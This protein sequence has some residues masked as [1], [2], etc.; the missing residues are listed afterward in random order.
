MG[1]FIRKITLALSTLLWADF[2]KVWHSFRKRWLQILVC[3]VAIQQTACTYGCGE[4]NCPEPDPIDPALDCVPFFDVNAMTG[5][6]YTE[7]EQAILDTIKN[8][9]ERNLNEWG[10]C[11]QTCD[12]DYTEKRLAQQTCPMDHIKA[13]GALLGYECSHEIVSIEEGEKRL[14]EFYGL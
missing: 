6:E 10:V 9:M 2:D 14:K 12:L 8:R 1:L 13:D 3:F 5:N 4:V 7:C 11:V